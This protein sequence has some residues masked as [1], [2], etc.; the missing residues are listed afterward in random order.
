ML[1]VATSDFYREQG[2]VSGAML[3]EPCPETTTPLPVKIAVALRVAPE[4]APAALSWAGIAL[5]GI[6]LPSPP[7]GERVLFATMAQQ[8]FETGS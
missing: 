1:A 7:G 2:G 3:G 4:R 5:L 6:P 8:S